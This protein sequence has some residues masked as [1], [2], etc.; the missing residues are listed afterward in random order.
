MP[1]ELSAKVILQENVRFTGQVRSEPPVV[2]DYAAPSGDGA[3]LMPLELLLLSLAGCSGQTVIGLLHMME[4][5][6]QGL[7]VEACGQRQDEHPTIFTS[8]GLEFVVHGADIDPA[9]VARAIAL[10]EE[11]YSPIWAMLKVG[12]TITSSFRLVESNP[13]NSKEFVFF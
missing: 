11:R 7:E 6:V 8:I 2:I 5:P 1:N 10:S 3:G 12:T 9:L 4:Q 13:I